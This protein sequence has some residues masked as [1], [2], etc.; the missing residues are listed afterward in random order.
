[1]G[2]DA[3]S[4]MI[5]VQYN[6]I[7]SF[8]WGLVEGAKESE[9]SNHSRMQEIPGETKCS[10]GELHPPIIVV[11][12][13]STSSISALGNLLSSVVSTVPHLRR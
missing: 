13:C 6:V 4:W 2:H 12:D 5:F 9:T 3:L 10:S 1:M 7:G 11:C 8:V